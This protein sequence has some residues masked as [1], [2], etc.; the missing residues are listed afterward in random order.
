MLKPKA[1]TEEFARAMAAALPSATVTVQGDL[2]LIIREPSGF[3]NTTLLANAYSEYSLEPERFGEIVN[4][5]VKALARPRASGTKVDRSNIVPIIRDRQWLDDVRNSLEGARMRQEHL[6]EKLNDELIIVYAE[7]RPANIRYLA[8]E[9]GADIGREELRALA[10][11]NLRRVLP[12]VEKRGEGDISMITAGGNYEASLL[13]LDEIWSGGQL[14]VN[15]DIVVAIPTRDLLLVTG[16]RNRA[17]V[18][19]LRELAAKF[20][21]QGPYGLTDA[22]FVYRNGRFIR[23]GAK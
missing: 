18:K 1:F 9:E 6:T 2:E 20:A 23:F 12:E 11:T 8:I 10:I 21:A 5:F 17:G 16:S 14:K 15:G 7:D 22:L 3:E 19:R 13:L 4:V